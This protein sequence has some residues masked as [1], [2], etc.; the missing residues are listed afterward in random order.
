ME[1]DGVGGLGALSIDSRTA[2]SAEQ[3]A[4]LGSNDLQGVTLARCVYCNGPAGRPVVC[5]LSSI[6]PELLIVCRTLTNAS[7]GWRTRE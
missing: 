3:I 6:Q 1:D 4:R 2:F 5:L 7:L